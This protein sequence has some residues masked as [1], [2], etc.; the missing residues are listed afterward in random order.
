MFEQGTTRVPL[1]KVSALALSLGVDQTALVR[2]WLATYEP[3]GLAVIGKAF[4]M[5]VTA[6]E[7]TWLDALRREFGEDMPALDGRSYAVIG[8]RSA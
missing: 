6:A 8:V 5:M 7:R 3:E 2:L 4:G 1:E